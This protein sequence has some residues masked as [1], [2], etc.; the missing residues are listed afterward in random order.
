MRY[1]PLAPVIGLLFQTA[2]SQNYLWPTNASR[3][4][5]S[6]FGE[7]R[8]NHLHAGL[9]IKTNQRTGY[10]VYAIES[11]YI[12]TIRTSFT[13]Y[14]KVIYLQLDDGNVAVYAHLD[15]FAE[16]LL[17]MIR[18]EQERQK[19]YRVEVNLNKDE[20]RVARGQTIGYT[21]ETGTLHPHLH[22]ELR[23][24]LDNLFNPL[25]TNLTVNDKTA[26]TI[27]GIA[28]TPISLDARINGLPTTQ[29]FKT[30]PKKIN[31]YI[32]EK[33]IQT[34]GQFGIEIKVYDTIKGVPNVYPPYGIKLFI[35]DSL[36]FQ[37]QYDR[38]G[39]EQTHFAIIDR[40]YQLD[41]DLGEIYNRLWTIAPHKNLPM[42]TLP[43]ATGII[44]LEA[45]PHSAR[46][47]AYDK[48]QNCA[49]V[50][51]QILS[52]PMVAINLSD[53]LLT[54]AGYQLILSC[55]AQPIVE[56]FKAQWVN[57]NGIYRRP[58]NIT[59][60]DT[61]A[62]YKKLLLYDQ[63]SDNEYL[64]IEAVGVDGYQFQ[65]L[66][67]NLNQAEKSPVISLNYK[68]IHNPKNFLMSL[69]FSAVPDS[70]P[71]FYLQTNSGLKKV[72]LIRLSPTEYLTAPVPFAYWRDAFAFEI[73]FENQ[74]TNIIRG[75]LNLKCIEPSRGDFC[76][77][78]DSLFRAVFPRD[79]VFD[80]LLVWLEI[81]EATGVKGGTMIAARYGLH[82]ANQP[83]HDTIQVSFRYPVDVQDIGQIGIYQYVDQ[84]W[85]FRG[86]Q[87]DADQGLIWANCRQT[88]EFA[89][90]KD[91][92]TPVIRNLF[93][94]N[95]GRFHASD[96]HYLKATVQDQLS[97]IADDR[98]IVVALD[99]QPLIAEYN[100]PKNQIRYRLSR[101]LMAGKHTLS[102][103][104][105][106][107]AGN[108]KTVTSTFTIIP[109]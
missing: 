2:L 102:I 27:S 91:V 18:A 17:S 9:D 65:P 19:R 59:L 63:P 101:Q 20:L 106:D 46:I 79:A 100:A 87:L 38:F 66:F 55:P 28:V 109:G 24:S 47:I 81:K 75:Q 36:Y 58:A 30:I 76:F 21:G 80:S 26:P 32:L 10:P 7:Y 8:V 54:E 45:G 56:N 12:K 16:P 15:D 43:E 82:P 57:K 1:F 89:L 4:I 95:G 50:D 103:T 92:T 86:N 13:G 34:E 49:T 14:G 88:G 22:F 64:K 33:P 71:T 42:N 62:E 96:V 44:E 23:D 37:V 60:L 90:I 78:Q 97:G 3:L 53:F 99:G 29:T 39:Y 105:T 68:F 31:Q 77:S 107:R 84:S 83:L 94:G 74:I 35:D 72:E 73:R 69:T 67:I 104:A 85:C 70:S 98:A 40:N 61:T 93:P 108:V 48:N 52:A 25:N 41:H 11:G 6:T 5:S 51:F